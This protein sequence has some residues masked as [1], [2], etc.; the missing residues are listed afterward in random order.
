MD[1]VAGT[2]A[3]KVAARGRDLAAAEQAKQDSEFNALQGHD[4]QVVRQGHAGHAI[5]A[6]SVSWVVVSVVVVGVQ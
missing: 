3:A 2:M 1:L 6:V 5:P 4:D